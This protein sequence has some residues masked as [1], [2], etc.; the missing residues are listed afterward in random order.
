ME[1]PDNWFTLLAKDV[2]RQWKSDIFSKDTGHWP[3]TLL[4]CHNCTGVFHAFC[5][6]NQLP[7]FFINV[8]R[9]EHCSKMG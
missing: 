8:P 5:S 7:D 6:A 4:K 2:K 1:K 9:K 3:T